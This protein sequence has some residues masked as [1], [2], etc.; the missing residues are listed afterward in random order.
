MWSVRLASAVCTPWMG[1]GSGG[2]MINLI[3]KGMRTRLDKALDTK[4]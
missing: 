4:E 3:K 1:S 2:W